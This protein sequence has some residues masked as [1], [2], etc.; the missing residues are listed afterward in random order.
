MLIIIK[1]CN[2]SHISHVFS[3]AIPPKCC[4]AKKPED[5]QYC[6]TVPTINNICDADP[7]DNSSN[8]A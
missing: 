1:I 6:I 7:L 8:K 3:F 5:E 4:E 2:C